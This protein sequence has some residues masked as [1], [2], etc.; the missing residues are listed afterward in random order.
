MYINFLK[1]VYFV[2]YLTVFNYIFIYRVNV[3]LCPATLVLRT[4]QDKKHFRVTKFEPKHD[5]DQSA[6]SF[7]T[8]T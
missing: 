8:L 6:V 4:T 2:N 7:K 3:V 5:Y 1:L